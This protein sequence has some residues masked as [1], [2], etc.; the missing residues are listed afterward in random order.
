MRVIRKEYDHMTDEQLVIAMAGGD[1]RAFDK[2]YGRYASAL[3]SYFMRMLWRD[4]EKSEDFV[5]DFFTKLIHRPELF[6]TTRSF[7]TWMYSVASNMCKNEYK[8]QEIRKNTSNGLDHTYAVSDATKNT[9]SE[10]HH[11]LFKEAYN[12]QVTQLEDKH[13]EVFEMRH[14]DGLSIKE[15]AEALEI[16]E[17]TIKSRLFY[18][19]KYLAQGLKEYQPEH[20]K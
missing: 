13:R 9:E 5:H 15:I 8:K 18:A 11:T 2:L 12:Y 20:T 7:K 16:S 1:Q 14:F 4:R 3:L 19:T 10:V 17:G 6:D